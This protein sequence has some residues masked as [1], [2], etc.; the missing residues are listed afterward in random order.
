M[1]EQKR[2]P[3][4]PRK[5]ASDAERMRAT[6]ARAASRA[7]SGIAASDSAYPAVPAAVT[8]MSPCRSTPEQ[9]R[10]SDAADSAVAPERSR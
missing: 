2:K 9:S 6:R 7:R 8:T 10:E 1:G 5:W 3:G 4:R